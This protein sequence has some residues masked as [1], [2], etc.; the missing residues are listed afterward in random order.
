LLSEGA[1]KDIILVS[2]QECE[3]VFEELNRS[4]RVE[5][6][7]G[8]S[9]AAGITVASRLA[10]EKGFKN[11][12]SIRYDTAAPYGYAIPGDPHATYMANGNWSSHFSAEHGPWFDRAD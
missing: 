8:R 5:D 10:H 2:R 1:L 9:S 12:C 3:D 11:I 7:M 4:Q 6:T